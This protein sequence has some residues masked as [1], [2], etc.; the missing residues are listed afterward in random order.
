MNALSH[1][2]IARTLL[3]CFILLCSVGVAFPSDPPAEPVPT[4]SL[5]C[6]DAGLRHILG[7]LA[8]QHEVSIAGLDAIPKTVTVTIS[9]H[10]VPFDAGL[11]AVLEPVGFTFDKRDGIYFISQRPP[12][13]NRLSLTVS[14]DGR[15]TLE[16]DGV[17]VNQVVRA[18]SQANIS[19]TSAA[20]LTG[21]I[22]AYLQDQPV[23]TALPILFS[24]FT[25]HETDDIYTVGQKAVV[26]QS[27][28]HLMVAEGDIEP[29]FSLTAQNAS[30]T[31]LLFEF[32]QRA[33]INLSVVGEIER[34]VT[35]RLADQPVGAVLTALAQTTGYTY[36]LVDD[37][38]YF[39]KAEVQPDRN[40]TQN[41]LIL[42]KTLWL[43]HLPAKDVLNLLPQSIPK[44]NVTVS[45]VHNTV[46][47]V[48]P[49]PLIE[50]T[51]G[52]LLEMDTETDTIRTRQTEGAIA[53]E[54]TGE[55]QHLR[56]TVDIKAAPLSDV[57]RQLSIETGVDV[58]FLDAPNTKAPQQN[59]E[60]AESQSPSKKRS[61]QGHLV[62]LR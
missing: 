46:T 53:I 28:F 5:N 24:E 17:E 14:A 7:V 3:L 57:M 2:S 44:P 15:L 50:Q 32:A 30:L 58:V 41:P 55:G 33:K 1:V 8:L 54:A 29:R 47:V 43:K 37:T 9:L 10:D 62:T 20:N 60:G 27:D 39:G 6:R 49:Q 22:T 56:L 48:G 38:H 51:V 18:L 25:L 36:R 52:F 42:R 21:Y 19:I 23:E 31:P 61:A 45:Q 26:G 4:F 59:A 40:S 35:L 12:L 11:R 16:A 13:S 34:R